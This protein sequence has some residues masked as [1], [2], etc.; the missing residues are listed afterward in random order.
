MKKNEIMIQ[1]AINRNLG[2]RI[3][4]K[5]FFNGLNNI[6]GELIII[7]F[8]NVE[9]MSRSFA[10][11]YVQQKKRINKTIEEKNCPKVVENMLDVVNRSIKP[12]SSVLAGK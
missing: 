10:Q 3:S 5:E 12:K 6:S 4:A 1:E 7:N 11:E 2:M 8:K 9:Y